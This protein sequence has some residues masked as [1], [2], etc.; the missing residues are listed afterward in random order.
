MDIARFKEVTRRVLEV[1]DALGLHREAVSVPLDLD[2]D[3][4]QARLGA[5]G[6]LE[7]LGPAEGSIEEFAAALPDMIRALDLS[8]I[9]RAD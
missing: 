6:K 7:I 4:G 8:S 5:P 3:G 9:P 1:T 2:P